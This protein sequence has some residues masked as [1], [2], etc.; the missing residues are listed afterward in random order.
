MQSHGIHTRDFFPIIQDEMKSVTQQRLT[1]PLYASDLASF[2]VVLAY[3][4]YFIFEVV[5]EHLLLYNVFRFCQWFYCYK[6]YVGVGVSLH[7]THPSP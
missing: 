1:V 6:M 5:Q 4:S 7:F 2:F 3:I